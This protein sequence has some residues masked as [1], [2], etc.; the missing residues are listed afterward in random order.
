M[1]EGEEEEPQMKPDDVLTLPLADL[2]P[3]A[4]ES[5][6]SRVMI[7][8]GE[9]A[10]GQNF[11]PPCTLS[12]LDGD[13]NTLCVLEVRQNGEKASCTWLVKPDLSRF[14]RMGFVRFVAM[15]DASGR[16]VLVKVRIEGQREN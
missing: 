5:F 3:D 4:G 9:L 7:R 12:L 6:F 10:D 2:D 16:K 14:H 8:A 1:G 11:D 15:E 13:G